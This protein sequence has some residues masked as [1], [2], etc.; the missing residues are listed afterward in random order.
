LREGQEEEEAPAWGRL[1]PRHRSLL[2]V[3]GCCLSFLTA[4]HA[5]AAGK[6]HVTTYHS[7]LK[8]GGAIT[9]KIEPGKN[10]WVR[11]KS[12][13]LSDVSMSC[14]SL[15]NVDNPERFVTPFSLS[16]YPVNKLTRLAP[17]PDRT[18]PSF[19][20]DSGYDGFPSWELQVSFPT[21]SESSSSVVNVRLTDYLDEQT[22]CSFYSVAAVQLRLPD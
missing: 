17:R 13:A 21:K 10:R 22:V 2:V 1:I 4:S 14:L 20:I 15:H 8:K 5:A 18:W 16:T 7:A 9:L 19:G 3:V 6:G 11:I 12:V